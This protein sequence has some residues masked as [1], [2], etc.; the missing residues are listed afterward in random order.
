MRKII[1]ISLLTI[2]A[3]V[4]QVDYHS[5]IQPIFDNNCSGCHGG[6]AGVTVTSYSAVMASV[7]NNYGSAIV[8]PFDAVN[9]PLYDKVRLDKSPDN[10]DRMPRG[11]SLSQ[12]DVDLIMNWINEGAVEQAVTTVAGNE[13]PRSFELYGNF[14]N[15][16]NPETQISFSSNAAADIE[17]AVYNLSGQEVYKHK[18]QFEQGQHKLPVRM[19][20]Q[21]S[22]IYVYQISMTDR[23]GNQQ[24]L[25]GKM[26]LLK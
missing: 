21:P 20:D 2:S 1:A 14:P 25:S 18:N 8:V 6:T 5:Q 9:S 23:S 12:A 24:I 17:L 11:G 10:G 16:Y 4:A 19:I 13:L 26:T 15:P 3:L 22:G 7:G